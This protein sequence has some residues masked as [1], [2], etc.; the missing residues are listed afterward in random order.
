MNNFLKFGDVLINMEKV[1][2]VEI[3]ENND[4]D[5]G[6]DKLGLLF[7]LGPD[8]S[9]MVDVKDREHAEKIFKII[10]GSTIL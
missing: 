7:S 2:T 1:L 3:I 4:N 9:Q 10:C 8:E 6:E 5:E